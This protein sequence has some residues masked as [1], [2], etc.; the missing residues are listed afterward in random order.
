[1]YVCACMCV[2]MYVCVYVCVYVCMYVC[3]YVC[4]YVCMYV[5]MYVCV[6]V[7]VCVYIHTQLYCAPEPLRIAIHL[8]RG[9]KTFVNT[10]YGLFDVKNTLLLKWHQCCNI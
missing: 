3:M 10:V 6:C 2:C 9:M 7:C 4:V 1:M 8:T 5:C